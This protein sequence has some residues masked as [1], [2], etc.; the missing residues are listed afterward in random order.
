MKP[1]LDKDV[2]SIEETSLKSE[3]EIH[4]GY[5]YGQKID[6]VGWKEDTFIDLNNVGI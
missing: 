1:C 4:P 6:P 2:K 3:I 5:E